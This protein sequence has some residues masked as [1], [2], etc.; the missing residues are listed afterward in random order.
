MKQA[1]HFDTVLWLFVLACAWLLFISELSVQWSIYEQYEYGWAVPFLCA[2]LLLRRF[3]GAVAVPNVPFANLLIGRLPRANV[4][5]GWVVVAFSAAALYAPTRWLIQANPT[6]R[7]ALLLWGCELLALT[8]F[9]VYW[10]QGSAGLCRYLFPSGFILVAIPWP[11]GLET[12]I[13]QGF[14]QL[15]TSVAVETLGLL[16]IPAVQH[17]NVVETVGGSV[18]IDEA[19]SG[20]R[21]LQATLML[22][23]FLGEFYRLSVVRRLWI[24]PLGVGISFVSNLA[25]TT[26]LAWVAANRGLVTLNRWHDSMGVSILL[27]AFVALWAAARRCASSSHS[28]SLEPKIS[29]GELSPGRGSCPKNPGSDFLSWLRWDT[30]A[31]SSIKTGKTT[32]LSRAM[33]A[34][35]IWL[36]LVEIG[37]NEWY[38][39]G[40]RP[41]TTLE[42]GVH[43]HPGI[44]GFRQCVIPLEILAQFQSDRSFEARWGAPP[45]VEGQ[46]FFFQWFPPDSSRKRALI[47]LARAHEPGVCLPAMGMRMV[48]EPRLVHLR[49]GDLTFALD[50]SAFSIEGRLVYVF[51]GTYD[52][53]TG[54]GSLASKRD[55]IPGRF[56]SALAGR[57]NSGMRMLE[58]ALYDTE[59][60]MEP[61]E[62]LQTLLPSLISL[63]HLPPG[64]INPDMTPHSRLSGEA[65]LITH[66]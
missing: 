42:W 4:E 5:K 37:T 34:L 49:A 54:P 1:L 47:Q 20:I 43:P 57:R 11:S 65:A 25:R 64:E 36:V 3:T 56:A 2:W 44:P 39:F 32:V 40:A 45:G 24:V 6:W 46:L 23:L 22:S 18:G 21:S 35:A 51:F 8:L 58:I 12:S 16:G 9:T 14:A 38:H 50:E 53:Q 13:V 30:W 15:D 60:G 28:F 48:H 26:V 41:E 31:R 66:F 33:L 29:S 27:M 7:L 19:C 61:V 63:P 10:L 55:H 62:A 59:P 17:G 52:D